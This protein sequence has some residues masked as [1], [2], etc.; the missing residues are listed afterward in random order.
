[1]QTDHWITVAVTYRVG[2]LRYS[3]PR[4]DNVVDSY[5]ETNMNLRTLLITAS[6]IAVCAAAPVA[7]VASETDDSQNTSV[8]STDVAD[9][10]SDKG[11]GESSSRDTTAHSSGHSSDGGETSHGSSTGGHAGTSSHGDH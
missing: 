8:S 1:M 10:S 4:I 11:T 7:A 9:H 2:A 6:F 3:H 5:E